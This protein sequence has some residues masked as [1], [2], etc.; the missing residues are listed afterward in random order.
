MQHYVRAEGPEKAAA[1]Q[2]AWAQRSVRR[3]AAGKVASM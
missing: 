3:G 1:Q 2:D